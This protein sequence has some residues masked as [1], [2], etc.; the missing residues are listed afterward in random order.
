M[1]SLALV[2]SIN[3]RYPATATTGPAK[4]DANALP[5]GAVWA[6][7]SRR[8]SSNDAAPARPPAAASNSAVDGCPSTLPPPPPGPPVMVLFPATLSLATF[9]APPS[10]VALASGVLSLLALLGSWGWGWGLVSSAGVASGVSAGVAA[11]LGV[12]LRPLGGWGGV[13]MV[14]ICCT[15]DVSRL[16]WC[17]GCGF[18]LA[19]F[20]L[21]ERIGR[22]GEEEGWRFSS[23]VRTYLEK[24]IYI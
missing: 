24:H 4:S 18:V 21:G 15:I 20:F 14:G 9:F 7:P 3:D 13:T 1:Q 5:L 17:R 22:R 12:R 11:G 19:V 10:A 23:L 16:V 2:G 6:K 8:R